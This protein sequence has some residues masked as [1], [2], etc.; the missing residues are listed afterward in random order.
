MSTRRVLLAVLLAAG[1]SYAAPAA[2]PL[3][4][5]IQKADHAAVKRLLEAGANP[6]A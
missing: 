5:A 2:E 1:T 3:F 6:N 4:Q